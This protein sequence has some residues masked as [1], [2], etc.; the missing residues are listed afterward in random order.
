M[1]TLIILPG[2]VTKYIGDKEHSI[3][4]YYENIL[5]FLLF[6][7]KNGKKFDVHIIEF[8]GFGQNPQ[9]E[10]SWQLNDFVEY[11]NQYIDNLTPHLPHPTV[12]ILGHSFGGQVAA[13]FAELYPEKVKKLVLYNAACIRENKN[14][15]NLFFNLESFK[16]IG[17]IIF[18]RFPFL[19]KI[20]YKIF[21]RNSDYAKL[22]AI[23][24]KTMSNVLEEDLTDILPKIKTETLVLWGN[25][26]TMT[27][28][29]QGLKIKKLLPNAKITIHPG[30]H[31]FHLKDPKTFSEYIKNFLAP[32]HQNA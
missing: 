26:D 18:A 20:F 19:R 7:K 23:M 16:N 4:E 11:L 32:T 8:P 12:S 30:G 3:A 24:Q 13:K 9:P 17:R 2:W 27:P 31:S 29:N 1:E 25:T 28:L 14:S 6:S 15:E 21:V 5:P 22:S 10:N